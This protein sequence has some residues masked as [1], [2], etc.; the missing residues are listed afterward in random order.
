M[1][2]VETQGIGRRIR[3]GIGQK[4]GGLESVAIRGV[5]QGRRLVP[6][7]ADRERNGNDQTAMV[8]DSGLPVSQGIE[9]QVAHRSEGL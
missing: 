7:H 5:S 2:V 8:E 4:H 9:A 3:A 6:Q 1:V